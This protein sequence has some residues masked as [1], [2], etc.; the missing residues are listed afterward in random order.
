[1]KMLAA[2][3]VKMEKTR[4]LSKHGEGLTKDV[5]YSHIR[6][7]PTAGFSTNAHAEV[8]VR[9]ATELTASSFWSTLTMK[10]ILPGRFVGKRWKWPKRS[11]WQGRLANACM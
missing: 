11:C 2:A 6:Q 1:M 10:Q 8:V 4:A 5:E 9:C 3:K 7:Y